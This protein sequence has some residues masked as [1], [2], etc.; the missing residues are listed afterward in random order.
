[1]VSDE[2]IANIL[3]QEAALEQ[4]GRALVDNAN[5][6]GGR[7]NISVI[8]AMAR[9]KSVRRGLLSRMLRQQ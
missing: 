4:I 5:G 6:S 7:D 3:M 2:R 9:A 1:M 8:L